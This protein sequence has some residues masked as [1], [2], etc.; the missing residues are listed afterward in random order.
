[1]EKNIFKIMLTASVSGLTMV[2]PST[3]A[4]AADGDEVVLEEIIVTAMKRG[5]QSLIEIP[6][7]ITVLGGDD[8]EATGQDGLVDFLQNAA[9][10]SLLESSLTPGQLSVQIR[11]MNSTVGDALV[12]LYVDEV[13]FSLVGSTALP[14]VGAYDLERVEVVRGPQGTLYG[15]GAVSGVVRMIT[16]SPDLEEV[17]AKMDGEFSTTKGGGENWSLK[18]A[19]NLPLVKDKWAIRVVGTHEDNSGWIDRPATPTADPTIPLPWPVFSIP[20]ENINSS[21]T[22]NIR[23]KLLGNLSDNMTVSVMYWH[24]ESKFD[25]LNVANDEGI[26]NTSI[27]QPGENGFDMVNLTL[28]YDFDNMSLV[29]STSHFDFE[30][31]GTVEFF[32]FPLITLT[33][34]KNFVQEVRLYSTDD[35]PLQWTIGGYYKS[36]KREFVQDLSAFPGFILPPGTAALQGENND[37]TAYA[38]FADVTYALSD[39]LDVSAGI[40]YFE[41][42]RENVEVQNGALVTGV[43]SDKFDDISPKF[44]IA[45]HPSEEATLYVN[46]AK[47]FRSGLN[48]GTLAFKAAKLMGVPV[49][50]AA[51]EETLWSYEA[52]YKAALMDNKLNLDMAIYTTRWTNMQVNV[53]VFAGALNAID[54]AAK[55]KAT[56]IEFAMDY[57]PTDN[58][59]FGVSGNW[60]DA[61]IDED[62]IRE[63]FPIFAKGDR[64]NNVPEWTG[65]GWAKITWAM[66]NDNQGIFHINGQYTSERTNSSLG[67]SDS[68]DSLFTLDTRLGIKTE[69]W[70]AFIFCENCTDED[71]SVFPSIGSSLPESSRFRPRTIGLNLT[72]NF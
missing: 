56:G 52:G 12:G 71:G 35:S 47:G 13:P 50:A 15:A 3:W 42:T 30:A 6:A 51:K 40:R 25:D 17:S 22:T 68:S 64:I 31:E 10:V 63:G 45:W 19:L 54:N 38:V 65:N 36:S 1:M 2:A 61:K 33:D 59:S 60:N 16:K 39:T 41:E 43:N 62:L 66:G 21:Q 49:P 55:A 26:L 27:D 4:A 34:M 11:G 9:G 7:A 53:P 8:L 67:F 5:N 69:K 70:S 37:N 44:N 58:F 28:E 29:S 14:N 20:G 23:A 57:T 72:G 24:N 48:Q 46:V 32:S 18:G